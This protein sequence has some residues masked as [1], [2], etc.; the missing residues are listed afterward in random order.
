MA[1]WRQRD[2]Q[3]RVWVWLVCIERGQ[4]SYGKLADAIGLL[5][6]WLPFWNSLYTSLRQGQD[7]LSK[8]QNPKIYLQ[9]RLLLAAAKSRPPRSKVGLHG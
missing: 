8:D 4:V 6:H 3:G 1:L 7:L 2:C 9:S 5:V